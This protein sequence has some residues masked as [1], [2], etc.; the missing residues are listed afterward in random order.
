RVL[1]DETERRLRSWSARWRPEA[2]RHY[3][4]LGWSFVARRHSQTSG[5]FLAQPLLFFRG[6]TQTLWVEYL[7]AE[8]R[9][10]ELEL[11]DVAVRV[12]REKHLQRMLLSLEAESGDLQ[13]EVLSRYASAQPI[14]FGE[15]SDSVIEIRTTKG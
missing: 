8:D 13:A 11:I 10:A 4:P 15:Q 5:Y 7:E 2:L 14:W 12:A 9:E 1:A 6:Q 3:L